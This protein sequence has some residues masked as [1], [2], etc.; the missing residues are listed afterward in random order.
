[1][2]SGSTILRKRSAPEMSEEYTL[3]QGIPKSLLGIINK[4]QVLEVL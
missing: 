2:Q 4:H 3:G 1:M